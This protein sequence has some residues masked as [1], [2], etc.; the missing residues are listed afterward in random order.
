MWDPEEP[1]GANWLIKLYADY[2]SDGEIDETFEI[3]TSDGTTDYNGDGIDDEIGYF[4]FGGLLP[5]TYTL[6]EVIED[7]GFYQ[8]T[9]GGDG[10]YTVI[11][12]TSGELYT[13]AE[14][15]GDEE[16]GDELLFGNRM[17]DDPGV[18]TP[19]FWQS[20]LGQTFWDGDSSNE[21]IIPG[22]G[23]EQEKE[24]PEFDEF[25]DDDLIVL[26]YG[27]KPV[28]DEDGNLLNPDEVNFE[29]WGRHIEDFEEGVD[30][31][32]EEEWD[33]Y[34]DNPD[35]EFQND[36]LLILIGDWDF[37]GE[38]NDDSADV[39]GEWYKDGPPRYGEDEYGITRIEALNALQGDGLDGEKTRGNNWGKT[40]LIERD[41]VAAWLNYMAGNDVTV[42]GSDG[43][44]AQFWI[45]QAIQYLNY[46][47]EPGN[48]SQK[49]SAW[50]QGIDMNNDG[51]LDDPGD[52]QSGSDIHSALDGWNNDGNLFGATVT[53]V[54]SL[55][56]TSEFYQQYADAEDAM[57]L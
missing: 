3:R 8:T 12:D 30:K 40:E 28:Y 5:G 51:D 18:R 47:S 24:S 23:N 54:G 1:G 26:W 55:W 53:T 52:I 44:D 50:S 27:E 32:T 9:P 20:Q 2:D 34:L 4:Y 36:N 39:S 57:G 56:Q 6:E 37:D 45:D 17:F 43:N 41:L 35:T 25:F 13:N 7:P 15:E 48:K 11:V 38:Y 49:K 16:I 31:P 29:Y 19:G 10:T 22:T 14:P 33:T 42:D 21:G 46:F